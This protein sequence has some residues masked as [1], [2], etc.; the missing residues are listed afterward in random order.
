MAEISSTANQMLELLEMVAESE[1]LTTTQLAQ[2][3]GINRTVAQRLMATLYQRGYVVREGKAYIIGPRLLALSARGQLPDIRELAQPIMQSLSDTAQETVVLHRLDG[4]EA[5]VVA[6]ATTHTQL[7]RVHHIEGSRHG[8]TLGASGRALLAF[9]S[10][11]MMARCLMSQS[12]KVKLSHLLDEVKR[13]G[14]AYSQNELQNGV[15]GMAVPLCDPGGRV[16]FSLALLAPQQRNE[17]FLEKKPLLFQAKA[18]IEKK[19][20]GNAP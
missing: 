12:D 3:A 5:I 9:Q 7:V 11:E 2:R 19:L 18:A 10:T 16:S 20:R 13:E 14:M 4:N 15:V 17:G 6:Q 1:P 8:L